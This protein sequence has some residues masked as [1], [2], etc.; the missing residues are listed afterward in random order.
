[1][2]KVHTGRFLRCPNYTLL[3]MH[4]TVTDAAALLQMC[5]VTMTVVS[6]GLSRYANLEMPTRDIGT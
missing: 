1:M 4:A 6:N 3:T 2:G 5:K